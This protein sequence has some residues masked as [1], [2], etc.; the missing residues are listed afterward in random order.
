M[1][2]YPV[3]SEPKA[4]G[5]AAMGWSGSHR[6]GGGGTGE[7]AARTLAERDDVANALFEQVDAQVHPFPDRAFDVA[8]SRTGA[9]FFGDPAAAFA[10]IARA[11]RPGAR[12][13]L[14]VWQP[15]DRNEWIGA[16]AAAMSAGRDLAPPPPDAP[17]PFSLGDPDRVRGLLTGAGFGEPRLVGRSDPMYF[18]PTVADA[19]E[20][21]LGLVG[22][23]AE[24][25]DDGARARARDALRAS[26]EAHH[27][28]QG[29][30]YGS[31]TWF[32]TADRR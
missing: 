7:S 16:F 32:V 3:P 27:T 8:I 1:L 9:M 28:E 19:Y 11:I 15:A 29:V 23:M 22:W 2:G 14:L 18:G 31:A 26:I 10:N 20:F 13:A 25:L 17:G 21:V 30:L 24:E 4:S 12:L 5:V 6:P